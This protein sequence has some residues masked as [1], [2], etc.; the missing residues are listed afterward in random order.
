MAAIVVSNISNDVTEKQVKDFFSF[1]GKINS[2]TLESDPTT[3]N[4]QKASIVFERTSAAKTALLLQDAQL[5]GSKI[6]VN[7]E[8]SIDETNADTA[9]KPG[10]DISQEDKPR[11]AIVAEVLSHGYVL[12]DSA[13]QRSIEFDQT[14]GVS[15]TFNSFLSSTLQTLDNTLNVSERS[16]A[17]DDKFKVTEKGQDAISRIHTYFESALGTPTGRRVRDFYNMGQKNVIDIHNEA[18]RLADLRQS[19][20]SSG[21]TTSTDATHEETIHGLG[22][23]SLPSHTNTPT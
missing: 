22:Q 13:V 4:H 20:E 21:S 3:P 18:R 8:K 9:G 16:K 2:L 12:G 1:C 7:S 14:H 11:T 23:T 10:S 5:G 19:K 6:R 17:V 15:Q